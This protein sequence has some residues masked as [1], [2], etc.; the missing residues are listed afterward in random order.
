MDEF[1][2]THKSAFIRHDSSTHRETAFRSSDTRVPRAG[3]PFSSPKADKQCF[4]CHKADHLITDCNAWKRKQQA[5]ISKPKGVGLVKTVASCSPF[6]QYLMNV[7]FIFPAFVLLTG[8]ADDQRPVSVLR[9]TGGSQSFIVSTVLPLS[10]P[11][12]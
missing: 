6:K 4:F 8:R 7:S 9:D 1:A 3:T 10:L 11:V 12:V 2:H 5:A